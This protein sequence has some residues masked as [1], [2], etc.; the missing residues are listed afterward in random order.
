MKLLNSYFANKVIRILKIACPILC[1]CL[2]NNM[3]FAF[4]SATIPTAITNNTNIF[5]AGLSWALKI[6]G[7]G[8]IIFGAVS[9][10]RNKLQGQA[11]DQVVLIMI[12]LG[13]GSFLLGW[14]ISQ[15]KTT[16]SG[17]MF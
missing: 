5:E 4:A 8:S 15:A 10:A 2:L 3:A 11:A 14:W 17:F 13:G 9:F 16:A 6:G 12:G 1:L 7:M